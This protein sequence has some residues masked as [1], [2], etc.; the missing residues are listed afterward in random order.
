MPLTP[1]YFY[2]KYSKHDLGDSAATIAL[3]TVFTTKN[4]SQESSS[5]FFVKYYRLNQFANP[6]SYATKMDNNLANHYN[7][8]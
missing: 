1:P 8:I 4:V 5:D 6:T 2:K 7:W 3:F